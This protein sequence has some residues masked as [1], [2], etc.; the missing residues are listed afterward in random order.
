MTLKLCVPKIVEKQ[1]PLPAKGE[2]ILVPV[3]NQYDFTDLAEL[4][5]TWEIGEERGEAKAFVPPHSTG[6]LL[7]KPQRMPERGD[8]LSLTFTHPNG[9]LVDSYRLPL[10]E[11][12]APAPAYKGAEA[13]PLVVRQEERL[14]GIATHVIGKEFELA[15][16]SG[17]GML[18]RGRWGFVFLFPSLQTFSNGNAGRTGTSIRPT[19]SEG[20]SAAS[21]P[22]R[23]TD[24]SFL[25]PGPGGRITRRWGATISAAP[26]ETSCG[27]RCA[28]PAGQAF[29][30]S[31][32]GGSMP[33]RRW[34]R[35]G[36]PSTSTAGSAEPT[37]VGGSGSTTTARGS[38]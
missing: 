13:A 31:P 29:W 30:F 28:I 4:K 2:P 37:P 10:G 23:I 38:S 21:V 32:T 16:D 18:R 24:P 1:L 19:I 26:S 35:I 3:E 11:E 14:A 27:R 9:L 25:P 22:T 12:A 33:G 15:F 34:G 20:R 7:L 17:S 6:V 36:F 8:I 5:I